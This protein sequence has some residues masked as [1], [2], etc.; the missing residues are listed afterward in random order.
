M[1]GFNKIA[2]LLAI[3]AF[4]I[5]LDL[6]AVQSDST[7]VHFEIV[8]PNETPQEATIFW[9][10][11]L[12]SWDP[13]DQGG[14]FGRKEYAKPARFSS[15]R[16]SISITAPTGSEVSYKYTR[17][18]IFSVEEAADYTYRDHRRVTFD[19]HK[20]IHDTVRTWHDIPPNAL[21]D[22]WPKVS[23]EEEELTIAHDGRIIKGMSTMLYGRHKNKRLFDFDA[24]QNR[25]ESIEVSLADT[26]AYYQRISPHSEQFQ[27]VVAGPQSVG[28]PWSVFV[29]QDNNQVIEPSEQVFNLGDGTPDS[30][31]GMVTFTSHKENSSSIDSVEFTVRHA[32]DVPMQYRS[33][34]KP[35]APNLTYEIP[36]RLRKGHIGNHEFYLQGYHHYSF[37][38]YHKVLID[39]NGNDTLEVGS[40]SNETYGIDASK[41]KR[42]EKYYL[43][44]TFKLGNSFWTV[45]N[46]ASN[47]DWIRLRPANQTQEKQRI[48]EG[49][50]SPSWKAKTING[51]LLSSEQ[52][53]GKY[54]LLDFWGSWCG[55]CIE[56]IPKL[57]QAYQKF[58][59]ANFEI[60]GFAYDNRST[61]EKAVK[62]YDINW[63]Q[64][65]DLKGGYNSKFNVYG[66]PTYYLINPNGKIVATDEELG[67][68]NMIKVLEKYIR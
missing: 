13:G 27:L 5:T 11:S 68:Q 54:V 62:D 50:D 19:Q 9:A 61:L 33:S 14:T 47:G 52:L 43:H 40:G 23:L 46:V 37:K 17:G 10:G 12:N 63:P 51:Q 39:R 67:N 31:S 6:K 25:I 64:I 1:I 26:V 35:N 58:K 53:K 41:M 49:A 57:K 20:T 22:Q 59:G 3:F 18:S 45:A 29:D 7:T 32:T 8:V 28:E 24:S 34:R 2:S 55:P 16:W 30:W 4:A 44:P 60:I 48:A 42:N 36:F 56:Q 15:G 65:V 21:A 66:Y 38:D